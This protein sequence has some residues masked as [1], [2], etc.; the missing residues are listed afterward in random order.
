MEILEV[1]KKLELAS[2]IKHVGIYA[3]VS[4]QR[5]SQLN[6]L[7]NQIS[8]L[9][10]FVAMDETMFL[11]GIYADVESG[12]NSRKDLE[13]LMDDCRAGKI[14]YVLVKSISRMYR[15]TVGFLN[16]IRELKS[17][18]INVHFVVNN[19]DTLND[20]EEF[21]L[22]LLAAVAQ[23]ESDNKS[24][25]IRKGLLM[26]KSNEDSNYNNRVF[27]GYGRTKEGKL[28]VKDNEA[29]VVKLICKLYLEGYSVDRIIE[30]L[31]QKRIPSP[32]G[33]EKWA[34]KA[35][36][37]IL[38]KEEYTGKHH[39][40]EGNK[41]LITNLKY[42]EIISREMFD[43]VQREI[44]RRSNVVR[45]KDGNKVRSGKRYVGKK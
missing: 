4:S 5:S 19:V 7:K 33:N 29:E 16:I 41:T 11:G 39:I 34:K 26:A 30:Q 24:A 14:N 44:S 40:K 21:I 31:Y 13:R 23:S 35:I 15:D 8:G 10:D 27:Y 36:T 38:E 28:F 25:N 18:N 2:P 42:P 9:I 17:L 6:S 22:T 37:N 45:D 20:K 12:R 43:D 3:R 32:S 1:S